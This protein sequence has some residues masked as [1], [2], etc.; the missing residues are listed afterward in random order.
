MHPSGWTSS[1]PNSGTGRGRRNRSAAVSGAER[2]ALVEDSQN[3]VVQKLADLNGAV[4]KAKTERMQ[5]ESMYRQ[6]VAVQTDAR[7]ARH[8]S[9]PFSATS[10]SSSRSPSS[11]TLQRQQAQLAEKL[12]DRASGH[13]A[14]CSRRFRSSQTKLEGEIGKVVQGVRNEYQ[15][16]LAQEQSLTARSI[17]RRARRWR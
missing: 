17:R 6:L 9:R 8:V 2:R 13:A 4:T 10:S 7:G 15:A 14:R 12:G 3:I 11:P 1:S 5:K 16:A